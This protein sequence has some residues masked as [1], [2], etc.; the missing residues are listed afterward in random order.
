[1]VGVDELV[2]RDPDVRPGHDPL[3]PH[4]RHRHPRHQATASPGEHLCC[5]GLHL[6]HHQ[7]H[8]ISS[9]RLRYFVSKD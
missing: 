5:P 9:H 2:V 7:H 6:S 4:L 3:R 8:R 1:M